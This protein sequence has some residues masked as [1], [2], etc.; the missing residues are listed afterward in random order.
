VLDWL[1]EL[2]QNMF[3]AIH[4]GWQRDWLDP[5]FWVISTTG[6]GYVQTLLVLILFTRWGD[7]YHRAGEL[8]SGAMRILRTPS[9]IR[10]RDLGPYTGPALL[11]FAVC[12]ILNGLV[13]SSTPRE[14]PSYFEWARPQ[15]EFY[16]NSFSSGH[17]ATSAA[18]AFTLWFVSRQQRQGWIGWVA[19]G[20]ALLVGFS[21]I[22]RGVHWPT[23]VLSGLCMGLLTAC[24]LQIVFEIRRERKATESLS[25]A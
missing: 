25:E 13:K 7:L 11:A 16:Y 6:L 4:L 1:W 21:R 18:I 8:S 10:M 2:D 9:L 17:T 14:R 24:L 22:Y 23:D 5:V 3:R 15:E 12:G 19:V 20:W